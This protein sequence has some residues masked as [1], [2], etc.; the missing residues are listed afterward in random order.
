MA[1]D[2]AGRSIQSV[3]TSS[4]PMM[5]VDTAGRS[6]GSVDTS[7]T[8]MMAVDT[9]GRSMWSADTSAT[10]PPDKVKEIHDEAEKYLIGK[11]RFAY[12]QGKRQK[13]VPVLPEDM[14]EPL[15]ILHQHRHTQKI[16]SQNMFFFA[17]KSSM[18]HCSGWH[19]VYDTCKKAHVSI[20]ATTNR[21]RLSTIYASLDT[22]PTYRPVFLEHMGHGD[23]MNRENYICPIGLKEVRVMG[24]MLNSIDQGNNFIN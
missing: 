19:A 6:M 12:L 8:S 14:I 10:F 9:A 21:H 17:A 16:W 11:F 1:I 7:G 13:F 15:N 23:Q 20:N 5:A 22:D 4:T 2:T 3:D 18:R 24:K